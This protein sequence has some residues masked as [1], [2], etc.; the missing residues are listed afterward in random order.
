MI[1]LL[2]AMALTSKRSLAC[3]YTTSYGK[4]KEKSSLPFNALRWT[5]FFPREKKFLARDAPSV[6]HDRRASPVALPTSLNC[7]SPLK[8]QEN[9]EIKEWAYFFLM[10]PDLADDEEEEEREPEL[11]DGLDPREELEIREE[12]E[13]VEGEE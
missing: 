3:L 7:R 11:R 4:S 12:L 9:R 8:A 6:G 2:E 10:P 1:L 13:L 5:H